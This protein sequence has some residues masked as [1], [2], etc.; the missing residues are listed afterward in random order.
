[1]AEHRVLVTAIGGNIGQGIVKSL[2]NG[3]RAYF[4]VGIDME[5]LSA[6]FS[7]VDSYY[8]VPRTG[9]SGF[10]DRIKEIASKEKIEAIYVCSPTELLFFSEHKEEFEKE[11]GLSVFVNPPE[12][13]RI[14]SDKLMTAEFLRK[15]GLPYPE[16]VPADD[17][18]GINKIIKNNGFPLIVKPREGSSSKN[19]FLVNSRE[20]ID[21]ANILTP[22]PIVQRYL[23]DLDSEY[24]AAT[25]SGNDRKV[26]ASIV[27]HRDLIQGTTYRTE[28]IQDADITQQVIRI[29]ELLGAVGSCNLQFRLVDGKVFVFEINPRFSGTSGIRYLYGFNDAEMVFE[30][31]CLHIDISQPVLQPAV[32][33]RYWNEIYIPGLDFSIL[34]K[35]D[36][37]CYGIQTIANKK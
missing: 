28:L 7:L 5:P 37:L 3:K 1:M 15:S 31:F 21:A 33:L 30:L 32:V 22:H 26:R 8:V 12:V 13:V 4:I 17:G 16:T 27:L 14:G 24:T 9:D 34:R 35:G 6:G 25:V 23:P 19:V 18:E 2:R 11:L 10:K 36:K 29:V 20:E